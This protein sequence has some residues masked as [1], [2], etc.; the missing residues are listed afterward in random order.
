MI[1]GVGP[2]AMAKMSKVVAYVHC[3]NL[4]ITNYH[5]LNFNLLEDNMQTLILN[6]CIAKTI[7]ECGLHKCREYSFRKIARVISAFRFADRLGSLKWK[8]NWG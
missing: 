5:C 8:W 2:T 7:N 6:L 4:K 1:T 3:V